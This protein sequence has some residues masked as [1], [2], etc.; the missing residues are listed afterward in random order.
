M[1]RIGKRVAIRII[2]FA[3]TTV[4]VL[5]LFVIVSH[6]EITKL[7][8]DAE[9]NYSMHLHE[10]DGSLANISV[11]L[12]KALYA[13]SATQFSTLA[14]Q[15]SAE[16]TVAKNS[17]SQ[18]PAT[19]GQLQSVGKFLSQ[20]GDYALYLSKKVISGNAVNDDE[21]ETLYNLAGTAGVLSVSVSEVRNE[22]DKEGVWN[23]EFADNIGDS[24]EDRFSGELLEL[25]ELLNDSPSLLY[26]GPFSDHML[27]GKPK[28]TADAKTVTKEEAV[29]TAAKILNCQE[30][31]VELSGESKGKIPSY[32]FSYDDMYVSVSK[33][34]GYVIYI[35]KYRP[36]E[37][38]KVSYEQAVEIASD[39]L[40]SIQGTNFVSTYYFADEGVCTVNFAHKEGAT[41]CYPDL[42]KVGVS[43]DT[44]EV[45][46]LEAAGYIANH[47]TRSIATPKYSE[48]D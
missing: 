31:D 37:S 13:T 12:K 47:Y 48:S 20:V 18:L 30:T 28:M 36:V 46:L 24:V 2:S 40:N 38:Q 27:S 41:V 9:Y 11:A 23:G 25:E 14:A 4:M 8:T 32:D 15:L 6:N 33:Q 21:R 1:M 39:Y 35:R 44:G 22:Y 19:S 26:D 7:K 17:L 34:G 3:M 5:A 43:L 45:V 29:K 16:S 42:I 10:L